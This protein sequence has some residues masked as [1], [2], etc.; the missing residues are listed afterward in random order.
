MRDA[1]MHAVRARCQS[2]AAAGTHSYTHTHAHTHAQT[3]KCTNA[4]VT[5][6]VD[7]VR[8]LHVQ[9]EEEGGKLKRVF[10]LA[11][12]F[13]LQLVSVDRLLDVAVP[14]QGSSSNNNNNNIKSNQIKLGH[15]ARSTA[16]ALFART[17]QWSMRGGGAVSYTH[18]TLPTIYS[19]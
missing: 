12:G 9:D 10:Q 3:H 1:C 2:R 18:L 11:L 14:V 19:V 15:S 7:D 8:A 13:C 6:L 16:T 4:R 17:H 5:H